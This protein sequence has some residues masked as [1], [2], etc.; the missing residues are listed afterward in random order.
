MQSVLQAPPAA[1]VHGEATKKQEKVTNS[2]DDGDGALY[3][4]KCDL[5]VA[6]KDDLE[7]H[8]KGKLSLDLVVVLGCCLHN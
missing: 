4:G 2:G 1:A 7:D 5:W 3:C 6:N 8:K